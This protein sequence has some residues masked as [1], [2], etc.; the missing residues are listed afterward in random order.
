MRRE[1]MYLVNVR[2]VF[3]VL[4]VLGWRLSYEKPV[5][6]SVP[7]VHHRISTQCCKV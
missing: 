3:V 4:T 5:I 2:T 7:T 1:S 6:L